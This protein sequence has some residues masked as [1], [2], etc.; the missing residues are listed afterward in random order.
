MSDNRYY[1]CISSHSRGYTVGS[2]C[3]GSSWQGTFEGTVGWIDR[4]MG[5]IRGWFRRE[6]QAIGGVCAD[7]GQMVGRRVGA[8]NQHHA[9][10]GRAS[11]AQ[12]AKHGVRGVSAIL[13]GLMR[14]D[15]ATR[16]ARTQKNQRG[17]FSHR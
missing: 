5:G 2:G 3:G 9:A 1:V 13:D 14:R 16:P 12:H 6:Y 8:L 10:K 17:Y 7:R 4:I 11:R 15:C